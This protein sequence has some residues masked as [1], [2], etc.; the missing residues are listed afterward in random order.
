MTGDPVDD[1]LDRLRG[2]RGG[3]PATPTTPARP[4]PRRSPA[5]TPPGALASPG[6]IR[7]P[8]GE[9]YRPRALGDH[10]DVAALRKLREEGIYAMLYGPPGTGKTSL[11]E[12]AFPDQLTV[13]G[14]GD[15]AVE[16]FTV[17]WTQAGDGTFKPVLGPLPIAMEEGRPLFI[18]DATLISPKVL[19]V[20]YPAM[21][22]RRQIKVVTDD[23]E[24]TVT[25]TDGFYVVAGHNPGAPGAILSEALASRFAV[26]IEVGTDYDL[27]RS[28]KVSTQAI[29]VA[30]NLAAKQSSGEVGWAPQL[31]ELLA[32]QRIV[33]ALGEDVAVA[34]LVGIA[35]EEDRD[36]VA[37]VVRDVFG[38]SVTRLTLGKQV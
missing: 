27:A 37:A 25:A 30:K 11:V 18:D 6:P 24:R 15:T 7:R 4:R 5:S 32:F 10:A 3:S 1:A 28:L 12:A 17:S 26:Q 16:D 33:G 2:A 20:V 22:G 8:N 19:A 35:P 23:G 34:N 36:V 31:R 38:R 21:D 14:N 13:A 9:T 29:K